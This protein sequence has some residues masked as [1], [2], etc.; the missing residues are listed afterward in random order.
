[1]NPTDA[2]TA[3]AQKLDTERPVMERADRYYRGRQPLT[4]MDAKVAEQLRGR[5]PPLHVNW[6]RVVVDSL[7]ERLDVEG[8]RTGP[9]QAG[10]ADLWRIWQANHLDE[11]SQQAHT[12]ALVYGRSF[13]MVWAGPDPRTPRISVESPLQ[14]VV[15]RDPAT[16]TITAGLKRWRDL[17]GYGRALLFT[18]TD[19]VT[20]RSISPFPDTTSL[21]TGPGHWQVTESTPNPLGRVPIVQ[22]ANRPRV[23]TP[24]GESELNDVM[25]LVDAIAKLATDCMVA[26]EYHAQPRRWITG[27]GIQ[28]RDQADEAA[29]RI[30]SVWENARASKLWVAPG[31]G[32]K[33]GQFPES[34]LDNY[35]GAIRMFT[36][37]VAAVAGLPPHYLGLSTDN[38]ASAD[39]IRSAEAVLVSRARRR[40]RIWGEAWEDVMRLAAFVRDGIE[41]IDLDGLETIWRSPE[42]R[43]VAQEADAATKL[44]ATGIVDQR[45][46][47]EAL[48]YTPAQIDRLI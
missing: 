8:F 36:Q 44:Y 9:D 39:A 26:A 31:E 5:I 30:E 45:A 12:D 41:P 35:I 10:D 17:Q 1:M 24:D 40:Q 19:V 32:T 14:T 48:D 6:A 42:T 7:E 47:L 4:F 11:F 13:V 2:R 43:S 3:L 28:T 38:P 23:L 37:Q 18:P 46:A 15:D 25:P 16:G 21:D 27:M 22:L 33:F 34:S 20:Y 29:A